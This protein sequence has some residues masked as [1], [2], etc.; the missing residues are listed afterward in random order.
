MSGVSIPTNAL[1]LQPLG[2]LKHLR[3]IHRLATPGFNTSSTGQPHP[4]V[5]DMVNLLTYSEIPKSLRR[6]SITLSL[7]P[8]SYYCSLFQTTAREGEEGS[9][10]TNTT[11]AGSSNEPST[12]EVASVSDSPKSGST[13]ATP[14][15]IVLVKRLFANCA[16]VLKPLDEI[17]GCPSSA[18]PTQTPDRFADVSYYTI[19]LEVDLFTVPKWFTKQKE[20]EFAEEAA[21]FVKSQFFPKLN[22]RFEKVNELTP[23]RKCG[24]F[25]VVVTPRSR[26]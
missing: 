10:P 6:I 7:K 26:S 20:K 17:L 22:E 12:S 14:P 23:D 5:Q 9:D 18:C 1:S 15:I 25:G 24:G 19:R 11:Q 3:L 16:K 13:S 21:E 8:P 4:T 2:H